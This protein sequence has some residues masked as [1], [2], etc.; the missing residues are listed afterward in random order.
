MP[1]TLIALLVASALRALVVGLAVWAGLRL[2]R[3]DNVIA[4][5]MAWTLVLATAFLLPLVPASLP[6]PMPLPQLSAFWLAPKPAPHKAAAPQNLVA[7][8]VVEQAAPSQAEAIPE[9][10]AS[11]H[12]QQHRTAT[13]PATG[14][15]LSL[16]SLQEIANPS[17]PSVPS[18]HFPV[19]MLLSAL[20]LAVATLLLARQL[21]GLAHT[22]HIWHAAAPTHHIHGAA[23]RFSRRISSPVTVG[24][25]VLLPTAAS[26]W[27]E[28]RLRIV[29]AHERSHILEGDF[30]L[31]FFA[32]LY[33]ALCWPSPL[34]WGLKRKLY[35]LGE[36][37]GDR[38]GV[39]ASESPASYALL[40]LEFAA[41][42]RP[43]V[44]GVAMARTSHLS[45]RID[46]LLDEAR[47]HNAF[48]RSRRALL[49]LLVVPAALLTATALVRVEA[50]TPQ[51]AA[52]PAPPTAQAPAD[53]ATEQLPP[54]PPEDPQ[55]PPPPPEGAQGTMPPP[56]P[57]E[58][59]PQNG[60]GGPGAPG[61]QNFA[62]APQGAGHAGPQRDFGPHGDPYALVENGKAASQSDFGHPSA[63]AELIEKARKQTKSENFLLFEHAGKS[64]IVD[65][66]AVIARLEA[67]HKPMQELGEQ[68]KALGAQMRLE[69]EKQRGDFQKQMEQVRKQVSEIKVP[70]LT[71]EMEQANKALAALKAKQG[72]VIDRAQLADLQRELAS[73]QQQLARLEFG[74]MQPPHFDGPRGPKPG[75]SMHQLGGEMGKLG[76]QMGRL[77]H[78]QDQTT[79]S[80]IDDSLKNGKAKPVQ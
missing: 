80:I 68:M 11:A 63:P 38:A 40:I 39:E 13:T 17:S 51:Q 55:G 2:L 53:A 31:Q 77:A 32:G 78:E 58:G 27:S 9:V 45:Q 18:T 61:G 50:A 24:S 44:I 19:G 47:F 42:P 12:M 30:Y 25:A 79:R 69:G 10:K 49:A 71:K 5:K 7:A 60:P 67:T 64:F 48:A 33:A 75:D 23:V 70:D 3:I 65:D 15:T 46:R 62:Q 28:E 36:A 4:Q 52:Q 35:E 26:L 59:G 76:G 41:L 1:T 8:P 21:Y 6:L 14:A 74:G 66:P 22:L 56:P 34:G 57:P 72:S 43:T 20:Y 73:V 16:E 29:L 37:L 54:P